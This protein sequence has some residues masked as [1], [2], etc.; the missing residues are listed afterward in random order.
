MK[1]STLAVCVT[2]IAAL[3]I[4]TCG[5]TSSSNTTTSSAATQYNA[6]LEN[7]LAA[8]KNEI[9]SSS[10]QVQAWE[11]DWIN[12]TSARVQY[13]IK[14]PN[15]TVNSDETL[16]VFPTTQDATN[17]VNAMNLTAYSLAKTVYSGGAYQNATGHAPQL[18]KQYQNNISFYDV[19]FITQLDN[20]V[21]VQTGKQLS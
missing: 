16:T 19:Q 4:G 2:I 7:Y 1:P 10:T 9:Y 20:L 14:T 6:F 21:S 8:Y 15:A 12:S 18:Y 3:I 17:Y 5:C 13:T 11:V